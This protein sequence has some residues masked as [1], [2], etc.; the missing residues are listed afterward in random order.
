MWAEPLQF[1]A[2]PLQRWVALLHFLAQPLKSANK[3]IYKILDLMMTSR[4]MLKTFFFLLDQLHD[5]VCIL[6]LSIELFND[7]A[8]LEDVL[9]S[10]IAVI[11]NLFPLDQLRM[12]CV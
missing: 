10:W 8:T 5:A 7:P 4:A 9:K 1:W 12:Q 6:L 3:Y 2:E 11:E